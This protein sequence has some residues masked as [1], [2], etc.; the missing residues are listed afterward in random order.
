MTVQSGNS[1]AGQQAP[2]GQNYTTTAAASAGMS[3]S[4]NNGQQPQQ[5][6]ND[7]WSF[8]DAG[9]AAPIERRAGGADVRTLMATF[10]MVIGK[11]PPSAG[12][13][14]DVLAIDNTVENNWH[15]SV[16]IPVVVQKTSKVVAFHTLLIESTAKAPLQAETR[17]VGMSTFQVLHVPS[18]GLDI[19]YNKRIARAVAEAYPGYTLLNASSMVVPDTVAA[20]NEDSAREILHNAT[21]ACVTVIAESNPAFVDLN[22][23]K[24]TDNTYQNVS[25]A[26]PNG[27]AINIVGEPVRQDVVVTLTTRIKQQENAQQQNQQGAPR[28][29]NSSGNA[30]TV[31][32]SVGAF[33]D[34]SFVPPANT[35]VPYG[36]PGQD[37]FARTRQF[38][39]RLVITSINQPKLATLAS[40]LMMLYTSTVLTDLSMW[41]SVFFQRMKN[42]RLEAGAKDKGVDPTDVGILNLISNVKNLPADQSP[43]AFDLKS[44]TVTIGDFV[45]Y[46][47]QV[48]VPD[49]SIAI[50]VPRA[51]PQSWYMEV[52]SGAAQ[53]NPDALFEIVRAADKLTGN[54]FSAHFFQGV[55]PGT[56][57]ALNVGDFFAEVNNTVHNG[58]YNKQTADGVEKRDLRAVD[59]L[60]VLNRFGKM[61]KTPLDWATTFLVDRTNPFQR[62]ARRKEIIEATVGGK[63]TF[64][65]FSE[66]HTFS[67][68][69][70]RALMLSCVEA[71]LKPGIQ[72]N[73]PLAGANA[74]LAAPTYLS[75]GLLGN[76]AGQG[77]VAGGNANTSG[78]ALH[79][80]TQG[81]RWVN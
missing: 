36:M 44:N 34:I 77:F 66:R 17:D 57:P 42:H 3:A 61:D 69:L 29:I 10:A 64:T 28:S 5:P 21:R 7:M 9:L 48:F 13:D 43:D 14:I 27:D 52:F 56:A 53:G 18:D 4:I 26:V 63:V 35:N 25:I 12:F 72:Y 65:G 8:A 38:I 24:R 59:E 58:Y 62:M 33:F 15:Y 2:V 31:V 47:F 16:V 45:N 79:N 55:M 37:P 30:E 1:P 23:S 76:L 71:G 75:S 78:G 68:K 51:G 50:D 19:E 74:N 40:T 6:S 54:R 73:N 11:N 70:V 20:D 22:L 67:A 46:M 49:L 80:P 41:Q 60:Y 39:P 81:S 32:G